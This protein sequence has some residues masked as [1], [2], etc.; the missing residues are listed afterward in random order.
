M[1]IKE[2][3]QEVHNWISQFAEGYW[4][5]LSLLARLIE[6]TGELAREINHSYGEKPKKTNEKEG[7]IALELA[8]IMFILAA[9]AN[10]MDIDLEE[11]FKATMEKYRI[12]DADRW[13]K[14]AE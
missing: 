12:R 11:A 7:N 2:M 13:T 8:D 4:Q 3:Q 1:E 10:S 9:F 5:P 14:K 6:E